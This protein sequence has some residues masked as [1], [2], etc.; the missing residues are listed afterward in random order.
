LL[1]FLILIVLHT[2][3]FLEGILTRLRGSQYRHGLPAHAATH[4]EAFAEPVWGKD[5]PAFDRWLHSGLRWLGKR[6]A[7]GNV[8]ISSIVAVT[9]GCLACFVA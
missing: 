6:Q 3:V 9:K 8:G 7:D 1:I 5:G 2:G 4:M